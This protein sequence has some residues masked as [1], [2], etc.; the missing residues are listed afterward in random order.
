MNE[1]IEDITISIL[2][3]IIIIYLF[4]K[5][6]QPQCVVVNNPVKELINEVVYDN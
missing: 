6:F 1:P 2:A 3:G 5:L 4:K